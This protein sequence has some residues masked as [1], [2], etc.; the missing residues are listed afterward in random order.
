MPRNAMKSNSGVAVECDDNQIWWWFIPNLG[1]A[2]VRVVLEFWKQNVCEEENKKRRWEGKCEGKREVTI[3]T[4]NL[5]KV[6]FVTA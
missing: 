6:L 4:R 1:E 5:V 3:K 2:C